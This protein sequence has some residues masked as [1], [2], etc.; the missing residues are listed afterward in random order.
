MLFPGAD[1]LLHFDGVGDMSF[2]FFG[3]IDMQKCIQQCPLA[4][5]ASVLTAFSANNTNWTWNIIPRGLEH[6]DIHFCDMLK[7]VI[8]AGVDEELIHVHR[9][10]VVLCAH[11]SDEFLQVLSLVLSRIADWGLVIESTS[12][13][14]AFQRLEDLLLVEAF[15]NTTN[16]LMHSFGFPPRSQVNPTFT[17]HFANVSHTITT[18][19]IHDSLSSSSPQHLLVNDQ[20]FRNVKVIPLGDNQDVVYSNSNDTLTTNLRDGFQ[21]QL[22]ISENFL[23][24]THSET[25]IISS[26][27][28]KRKCLHEDDKSIKANQTNINQTMNTDKDETEDEVI[29]NSSEVEP[30]LIHSP[31]DYFDYYFIK[32]GRFFNFKD[33]NGDLASATESLANITLLFGTFQ[34]NLPCEGNTHVLVMMDAGSLRVG[35]KAFPIDNYS[36]EIASGLAEFMLLNGIFRKFYGFE[37]E[38][39]HDIVSNALH[40]LQLPIDYEMTTT[41]DNNKLLTLTATMVVDMMESY[42]YSFDA[43]HYYWIDTIYWAMFAMRG[44]IKYRHGQFAASLSIFDVA[45]ADIKCDFTLQ[46]MDLFEIRDHRIFPNYPHQLFVKLFIDFNLTELGIGDWQP[47]TPR[48]ESS[49]AFQRYSNS[50]RDVQQWLALRDTNRNSF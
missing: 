33:L 11:N 17:P 27:H 41:P 47:L 3:L 1:Q 16:P 6:A 8:F 4:P 32:Y 15:T 26:S 37:Y 18:D 49:L 5:T 2:K 19:Q 28:L 21:N 43:E 14:F 29:S 31:G 24:N 40:L 45:R 9:S 50:S 12:C 48:L 35:L 22:D 13:Y 20:H 46:T 44:G 42:M 7:N 23:V 34:M 38:N 30:I 10:S 36:A 39:R 25:D